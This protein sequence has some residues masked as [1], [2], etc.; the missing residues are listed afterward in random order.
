MTILGQQRDKHIPEESKKC[1]SSVEPRQGADYLVGGVISI[2]WKEL[3]EASPEN[4]ALCERNVVKTGASQLKIHI[5]TRETLPKG[6]LGA[7]LY[8]HCCLELILCFNPHY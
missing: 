7:R 4:R 8:S 3:F 1:V 6:G 2:V 5:G